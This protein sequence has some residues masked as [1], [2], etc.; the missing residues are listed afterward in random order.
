MLIVN[1]PFYL[2]ISTIIYRSCAEEINFPH[3]N[4]TENIT[5]QLT[6][7]SATEA[8]PEGNANDTQNTKVPV[9]E[10]VEDKGTPPNDIWPNGKKPKWI[11]SDFQE[12]AFMM[13]LYDIKPVFWTSGWYD[14]E[15]GEDDDEYPTETEIEEITTTETYRY[16]T[17]TKKT[18][19]LKHPKNSKKYLKNIRKNFKKQR[20]IARQKEKKFSRKVKSNVTIHG[21][22]K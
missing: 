2:F 1:S 12:F 11:R 20:K 7:N 5:S 3:N 13:G 17:T 22:W 4:H 8:P 9:F 14:K 19:K 21:F 6:S 16:S 10:I 15:Y 18:N